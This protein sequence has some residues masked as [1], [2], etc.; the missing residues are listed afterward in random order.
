[1]EINIKI[2]DAEWCEV[3]NYME[4]CEKKQSKPNDYYKLLKLYNIMQRATKLS[5]HT[6]FENYKVPQIEHS[7]KGKFNRERIKQLKE[8]ID[9][10]NGI[11]Y[12]KLVDLDTDIM[13][14]M[15]RYHT[16]L[17]AYI[18]VDREY[19]PSTLDRASIL[20]QL[21]LEAKNNI[22]EYKYCASMTVLDAYKYLLKLQDIL[23]KLNEMQQN[24]EIEEMLKLVIYTK[25]Q[26]KQIVDDFGCKLF[27]AN[28][29]E[30]EIAKRQEGGKYKSLYYTSKAPDL[31]L[32]K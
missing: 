6:W 27:I 17:R 19:I 26:L 29:T 31:S 32:T 12:Y 8:E 25:A 13:R 14:W 9:D 21:N 22:F 24:K 23:F 10:L 28:N 1:M 30:I 3:V 15:Q 7:H 2:K 11:I 5:R 4:E 16:L 20:K 18:Q